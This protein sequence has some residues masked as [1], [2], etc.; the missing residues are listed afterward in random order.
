MLNDYAQ[1]VEC[2]DI[3]HLTSLSP[4]NDSCRRRHVLWLRPLRSQV[5]V[6]GYWKMPGECDVHL[7]QESLGSHQHSMAC[8]RGAYQ[9]TKGAIYTC[10]LTGGRCTLLDYYPVDHEIC[11]VSIKCINCSISVV[12]GLLEC[13]ISLGTRFVLDCDCAPTKTNYNV[14]T[15]KY[16]PV[17]PVPYRDS[18]WLSI[19][20][21]GIY[22]N[23]AW[24]SKH[25]RHIL[26][27]HK[28]C[29]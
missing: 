27:S 11:Q 22:S 5:Q 25:P 24:H 26:K 15:A 19:K 23:Q 17:V 16:P 10:G 18:G 7:A 1:A 28:D 21:A 8:M 14:S 9:Q 13:P 4:P 29:Y 20:H 2:S 6:T 3:T 12:L